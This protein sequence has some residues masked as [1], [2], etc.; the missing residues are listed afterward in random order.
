MTSENW[1]DLKIPLIL[2][3]SMYVFEEGLYMALQQVV[4]FRLQVTML[5]VSR[6]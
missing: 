4:V 3:R 5:S 6:V 1:V 2:L